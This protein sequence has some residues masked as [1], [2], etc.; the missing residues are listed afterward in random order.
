MK[1]YFSDVFKYSKKEVII[2]TADSNL[3]VGGDGTILFNS[4]SR[5]PEQS[6]SDDT[7]N[8]LILSCGKSKENL[9]TLYNMF[10]K[11][12]FAIAF[13]IT[14]D[15]HLSEDCVTETFIRLTQ[16]KKFSSRDG[17]GRGFILTVAKN[18]SKE[19]RRRYKKECVSMV[20]QGYGDAEKTVEDSIF[21]NQ[22]MKNLDENQRQIVVM[23]IYSEMTFK[24]I[25]KVM[26]SPVTTVKS[27]YNRA[28][29]ILKEKAGV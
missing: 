25:A 1:T 21:L 28:M 10:K 3:L 2:M 22:L 11:S 4:V 14:G 17:D 24:E 15:F 29:K 16:V 12:V 19:L 27:R 23:K 26:H 7:V 20:I 18:V 13:S 6:E 9:L 5:S 8:Q